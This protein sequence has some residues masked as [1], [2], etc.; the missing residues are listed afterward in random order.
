MGEPETVWYRFEERRYAAPL[1][2]YE[3]PIPG[4]SRLVV[5]LLE[6]PLIKET[7]KGVWLGWG[8]LGAGRFVLRSAKKRYACPTLE[9]AKTS[10]RARKEK[11]AGIYRARAE[12]ADRAIK[13]M[14]SGKYE[15]TK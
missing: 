9:E 8:G 7:P 2:E 14:D 1:D 11:Q 10:F 15:V 3:N 6:L 5:H 12:D 13:M 4:G